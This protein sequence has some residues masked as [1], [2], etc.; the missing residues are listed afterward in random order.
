MRRSLLSCSCAPS[1]VAPTRTIHHPTGAMSMLRLT[2]MLGGRLFPPTGNAN[3]LGRCLNWRE[4]ERL[5]DSTAEFFAK[6]SPCSAASRLP[7]LLRT[8]GRSPALTSHQWPT[9]GARRR[10]LVRQTTTLRSW[11]LAPR[12]ARWKPTCPALK[13]W[14]TP[15]GSAS[16]SMWPTAHH[17]APRRELHG[18]ITRSAGRP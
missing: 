11:P 4:Y 15:P 13:E 3:C 9:Q 2:W 17:G 1:R 10:L 6:C 5:A 7:P 12:L 14:T 18:A 16:V 8:L